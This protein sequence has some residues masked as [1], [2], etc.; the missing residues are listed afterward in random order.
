MRDNTLLNVFLIS[1]LLLLVVLF[2]VKRANL[3]IIE[4]NNFQLIDCINTITEFKSLKYY[5]NYSTKEQ[6]SI[7]INNVVNAVLLVDI[8]SI[9]IYVLVF[10]F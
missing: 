3:K 6:K 8:L 4:G 9:F 2:F 5:T 7:R 10:I 1:L